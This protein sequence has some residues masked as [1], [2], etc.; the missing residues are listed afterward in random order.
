MRAKKTEHP[1][2][3]HDKNKA[4]HKALGKGLFAQPR[5]LDARAGSQ[6][7]LQLSLSFGVVHFGLGY[8]CDGH[9]TRQY[10]IVKAGQLSSRV[11]HDDGVKRGQFFDDFL[12]I[13]V[14]TQV[15]FQTP[16]YPA[17]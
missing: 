7:S 2:S 6:S 11:Q 10:A 9:C 15:L 12:F 13:Q 16:D 17:N 8:F 4:A 1:A 14:C 3:T 5:T